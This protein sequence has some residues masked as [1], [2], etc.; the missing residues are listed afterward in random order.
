MKMSSREFNQDVGRAKRES[1]ASP[2]IITERGKPSH[3]LI[4]Y[5]EYM[6]LKGFQPKIIDLLSLNDDIDFEP[7]KLSISPKQV[8]FD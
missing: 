8:D 5:D 3:V 7:E 2:V 1:L 6:K 4:N